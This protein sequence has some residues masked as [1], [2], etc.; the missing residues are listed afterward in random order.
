MA[1]PLRHRETDIWP[2]FV[3]VLATLLMVIIFVLMV[4]I[5]SQFYLT[6][7]LSGRDAALLQLQKQVSELS[8]LLSL[9]RESTA[10]LRLNVAQLSTELNSSIAAR[11]TLQAQLDQVLG[12]RD[13]LEDRLATTL[14]E[15]E[16]L[17]RRISE[18]EG[19]KLGRDERILQ[20]IAERDA[21]L[22]KLN[23]VEEEAR[24][25]EAD[26]DEVTI[27]LQDAI[28][29]IDANRET[30]KLQLADIERLRRDL[31]ALKETRKGLEGDI[32]RLLAARTLLENR[33][34]RLL[35][36]VEDLDTVLATTEAERERALSEANTLAADLA[37]TEAE[38]EAARSRADALVDRLAAMTA[39]RDEEQ[40][41]RRT[42]EDRTAE[43]LA[44][45]EALQDQQAKTERQVQAFETEVGAATQRITDLMAELAGEK[46]SVETLE[47]EAETRQ[48]SLDETLLL[49]AEERDVSK[50][51]QAEIDEET[52]RTLLA[53]EEIK[54]RDLR[55]EE[56]TLNATRTENRLTEEQRISA[57][58]L[59]QVTALNSQIASLR[60]Q[61]AAIEEALEA[62]EAKNKERQVQIT[63]LTSRL[64][65][66][67]ASKVQELARF[68]SEFFGRLREV[69]S[70]RRDVRIVGDRFIFQSEVLFAS[71]SAEIGAEG[72]AQLT[73]LAQTLA[74][75][76]QRI[77]SN[78]NWILQV[79]GHTDRNPINTPLF[80]SNWDLSAARAISVVNLLIEQGIPASRLSATGYG[81]FQPLEDGAGEVALRRN[82]RIELKLTQR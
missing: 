40:A 14:S 42:A 48:R 3:D 21:L 4:F 75:I 29:V 27:G 37:K 55:L 1:A 17:R 68:R 79:E 2:G 24:L 12:Q 57:E 8:D 28:R 15:S 20:V 18:L 39:S 34:E 80:R 19:G 65:Q 22:A 36:E 78:I 44:A 54:E 62:S 25:V 16:A 71:G 60:L 61:L 63:S 26:R 53:Q 38:R 33:V 30:I 7:A 23:A 46:Q 72:Q 5:V 77:P 10:E 41:G 51:L 70:G 35:D 74:D 69:L 67:L 47:A 64:N 50:A 66:A 56:L 13:R 9:E 45:L 73:D 52:E 11:D 82:R 81:E 49:L 43:L 58:A 76:S 31:A 32:A 59:A 6:Q